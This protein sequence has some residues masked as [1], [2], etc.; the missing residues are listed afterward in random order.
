[1]GIFS[2]SYMVPE[3]RQVLFG[4]DT[5]S[6]TAAEASQIVTTTESKRIGST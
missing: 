3:H 1:M 2:S 6:V 4:L 5:E